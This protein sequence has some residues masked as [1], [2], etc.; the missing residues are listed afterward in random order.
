MVLLKIF[1]LLLEILKFILKIVDILICYALVVDSIVVFF[2]VDQPFLEVP[3]L[4]LPIYYSRVVS[5]HQLL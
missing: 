1:F 3:N 4:L 5:I 2:E